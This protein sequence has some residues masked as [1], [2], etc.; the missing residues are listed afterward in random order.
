MA[1]KQRVKLALKN[2]MARSKGLRR[3]EE[4]ERTKLMRKGRIGT[5]LLYY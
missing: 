2:V 3:A 1:A 5:L 4:Y